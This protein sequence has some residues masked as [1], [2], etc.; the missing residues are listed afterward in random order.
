[1][2]TADRP[3]FAEI[4]AE[5]KARVEK[6]IWRQS[7]EIMHG[8]AVQRGDIGPPPTTRFD[9]WQGLILKILFS[10]LLGLLL[11]TVA[12]VL[13]LFFIRSIATAI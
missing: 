10:L 1:M 5:V 13:T 11:G 7:F 12:V 6:N 8:E 9:K 3:E 4:P 2:R